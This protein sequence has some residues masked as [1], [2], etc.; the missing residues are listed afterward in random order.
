M[1]R[2]CARV[3]TK[4]EWAT[5]SMRDIY[6]YP[7]VASLAQH[8]RIPEETTIATDERVL[9]HQASNFAYWTCGAAQLLFYG[10][11][12]YFSLWAFNL[13]LNWV[14]DKLDEPFQLYLRCV[15]LSGGVFFGMSGFAIVAKWLLVGRWKAEAFRSGACAITGSG[16]SRP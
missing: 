4:P 5:A 12:S 7:T 13:G 6:L 9:T 1:A 16:S 15:L 10:L 11:Y 2:F 3:R 8:L 14:Y